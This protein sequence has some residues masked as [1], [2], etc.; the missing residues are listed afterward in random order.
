MS[1]TLQCVW[2]AQ[3]LPHWLCWAMLAWHSTCYTPS[4]IAIADDDASTQYDRPH[5][6]VT[7]STV[8]STRADQY[9]PYYFPPRVYGSL[10][11]R[12]ERSGTALVCMA[13]AMSHEYAFVLIGAY[14]WDLLELIR[15]WERST[16]LLQ[17][18]CFTTC[19]STLASVVLVLL[20]ILSQ[21]QVLNR[22]P[23]AGEQ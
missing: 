23:F 13:Y 19:V 12:R 5:V 7:C 10:A 9:H 14:L 20:A 22:G 1:S 2:L 11:H 17:R 8:W 4:C 18:E 16:R 21:L 15:E 6:L 3:Y